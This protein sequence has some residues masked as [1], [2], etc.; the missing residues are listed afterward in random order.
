MDYAKLDA[1]LSAALAE[2]RDGLFDVQVRFVAPL[3]AEE[4]GALRGHGIQARE[5]EKAANLRLPAGTIEALSE[6][7]AVRSIRL[8]GRSRLL[9]AD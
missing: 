7:P 1:A 2:R 9:D 6:M 4:A 3:A 5:G 8:S